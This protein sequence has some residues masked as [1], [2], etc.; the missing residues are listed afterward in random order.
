MATFTNRVLIL[1]GHPDKNSLCSALA[2]KYAT[3]AMD[4][5]AEVRVLNLHDLA[6]D[7]VLRKGYKEAQPLEDDLVKA[8][9]DLL[10]GTHLVMIYPIWWSSVPALLKGFI[11]RTF[12]PGFAFRY[13]KGKSSWEKLLKGRTSEIILTTDA[14]NWWNRWLLKDPSINM[15]KK[16]VL[17]F[18]GY[19]VIRVTSFD[20]VSKRSRPSIDQLLVKV[21]RLGR[22]IRRR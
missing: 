9:Q 20:N 21:E 18:C 7:P 12:L 14:P 17:E 16:G 11:D 13:I 15:V 8:Q 19:N 22:E 10:W 4:A 1:N 2:A 5:G 3:G 6:F